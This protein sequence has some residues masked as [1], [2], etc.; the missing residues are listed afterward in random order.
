MAAAG[1][2]AALVRMWDL[3]GGGKHASATTWARVE[4][5]HGRGKRC[6]P[7]GSLRLP[8]TTGARTLSPERRLH[9]I[10]KGRAQSHSGA[11]L[12]HLDRA[13]A[14]LADD[15]CRGD[16]SF[17][18]LGRGAARSSLAKALRAALDVDLQTA[19]AL[20]TKLKRLAII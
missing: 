19:R 20:V 10:C 13:L 15:A 9:K 1:E 2:T 14:W 17:L 6:I 5:L 3:L 18:A 12:L 4:R 16:E 8:E 11:A 7:R